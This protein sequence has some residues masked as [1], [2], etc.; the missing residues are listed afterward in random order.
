MG[1]FNAGT[2]QK[3]EAPDLFGCVELPEPANCFGTAE[4]LYGTKQRDALIA[5]LRNDKSQTMSWPALLK[6][7]FTPLVP[8]SGHNDAPL[9][10][11]PML[12]GALGQVGVVS[13]VIAALLEGRDGAKEADGKK[14][15]TTKNS[16]GNAQKDQVAQFDS[17]LPPEMPT[18]W[19]QC[20]LCRKWRRVA[21]FVNSEAL[22]ELWECHMNTWDLDNATC[23]AP[24]DGYDPDAENTLGFGTSEVAVNPENFVPGKKF[25]LYCTR[26]L[27][28]YEAVVIKL[29][30]NR[31]KPQSVPKAQFRFVGWGPRYDEDVPIDSDRIAPHNLHT[32]PLCHNPREQERWQGRKDL[33]VN[34][35]DTKKPAAATPAAAAVVTTAK[36][37]GKG[38]KAAQKE[39][40]VEEAPDVKATTPA[41]SR[42]RKS[43]EPKTEPVTS[44]SAAPAS[45]TKSPATNTPTAK[46]SASKNATK[47]T[48]STSKA[49]NSSAHKAPTAMDVDYAD[50]FEDIETILPTNTVASPVAASAPRA[51]AP[52]PVIVAPPAQTARVEEEVKIVAD[53]ADVKSES[54][55]QKKAVDVLRELV[56][57]KKPDVVTAALPAIVRSPIKEVASRVEMSP[58]LKQ[59]FASAFELAVPA[60]TPVS[61]P[62]AVPAMVPATVSPPIPAPAPVPVAQSTITDFFKKRPAAP[63][64]KF[65]SPAVAVPDMLDQKLASCIAAAQVAT[66]V[67]EIDVVLHDLAELQGIPFPVPGSSV[68]ELDETSPD[69]KARLA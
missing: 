50:D 67:E 15:G 5:L 60:P 30:T 57:K 27:V 7:S 37:K 45:A 8:G 52:V 64:S 68:V 26:N 43:I 53:E 49:K 28:Y 58:D 34:P 55:V 48:T 1:W 69:K 10:G 33:Y 40:S 6:Q 23:D 21:W 44:S 39:V 4:V 38:G 54:K 20:E 47:K 17:I 56:E 46:S 13:K 61:V 22:P 31:K 32:N 3:I 16:S 29:K 41:A 12:D 51:P 42:K 14:K 2:D 9:Y 62:V 36:G 63:T 24:Q 59:V 66:S 18:S 11:S 25:D 35:T 65:A 19:V